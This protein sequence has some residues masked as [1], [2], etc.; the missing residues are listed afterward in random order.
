M[1]NSVHDSMHA[2]STMTFENGS[3]FWWPFNIPLTNPDSSYTLSSKDYRD[4]S[5]ICNKGNFEN[6]AQRSYNGKNI[7]YI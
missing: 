4:R 1:Y 6:S 5:R 2:I 7:T 3:C